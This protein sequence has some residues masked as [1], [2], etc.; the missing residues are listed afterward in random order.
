MCH[1]RMPVNMQV[2]AHVCRVSVCVC[3]VS[4]ERSERVFI[5]KCMCGQ[6]A[7]V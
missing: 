6:C 1:E 2:H 3:G 5:C 4:G 7:C